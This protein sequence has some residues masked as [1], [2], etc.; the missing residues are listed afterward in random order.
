MQA[1]CLQYNI[2]TL[3]VE[4]GGMRAGTRRLLI[5]VATAA[6]LLLVAA[7]LARD[8]PRRRIEA[9]LPERMGARVEI[10]SLRLENTDTVVLERVA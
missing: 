7:W 10:A 6:V 4:G 5:F 1:G 8:L 3:A 2:A 9:V